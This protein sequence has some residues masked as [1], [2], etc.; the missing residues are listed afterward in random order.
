M[1]AVRKTSLSLLLQEFN[2]PVSLAHEAV[3]VFLQARNQVTPYPDVVPV[4]KKLAKIY[5]LTSITNGNADVQYTPLNTYFHFSLTPAIVGTAKPSPDIFHRALDQAGVEPH[6]AIHIGDH[7]EC[8][9]M[10]A[11]QV[12]MQTIWINRSG[13]HWPADL[14][15]PDATI[16]DFYGLEHFLSRQTQ[17]LKTNL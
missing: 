11:Q 9:V 7:P 6:Q 15:P 14:P 4:L 12:G 13:I 2:Y 17:K 5:P 8:D 3:T 1:T 10:A 16:Q